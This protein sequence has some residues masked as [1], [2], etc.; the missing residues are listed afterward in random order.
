[1]STK[2]SENYKWVDWQTVFDNLQKFKS[3]LNRFKGP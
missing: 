3:S 2:I 1:M